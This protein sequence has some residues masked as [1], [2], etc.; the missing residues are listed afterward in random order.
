MTYASTPIRTATSADLAAINEI[1]NHYVVESTCTYQTEPSTLAER[2]AW[3][4]E[5]GAAHPVTVADRSG[6]VVAWASLSP[7]QTRCGYRFTAETSVYVRHDLHRAGLGSGLLA[8]LLERAR[9]LGYHSLIAGISADQTASIA[10]HEKFGF[11]SCGRLREVGY[12]FER[13]LDVV[14]MQRTL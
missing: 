10:L 11:V 4:A 7:Y 5:H 2:A 8:D 6:E 14:Y 1:Y 3:F 9:A 13:W 12:K